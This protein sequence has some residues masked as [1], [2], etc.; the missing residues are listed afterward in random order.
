MIWIV[1]FQPSQQSKSKWTKSDDFEAEFF[2]RHHRE[3][4]ENLI[5]RRSPLIFNNNNYPSSPSGDVATAAE[6]LLCL[7]SKNPKSANDHRKMSLAGSQMC[8]TI[9]N[10]ST[11]IEQQQQQQS[12]N[13]NNRLLVVP[14]KINTS[15]DG[16]VGLSPSSSLSTSSSSTTN[17][18]KPR[19]RSACLETY[20]LRLVFHDNDSFIVW[21]YMIWVIYEFIFLI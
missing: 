21:Y 4:T 13:N 5:S 12:N 20:M 7:D 11:T 8:T 18:R 6:S 17:A 19:P 10:D 15:A 1:F 2:D 9:T 3:L 16:V 14:T